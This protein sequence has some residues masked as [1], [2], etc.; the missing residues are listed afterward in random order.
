MALVYSTTK[1]WQ[2]DD[3]LVVG[4]TIEEAIQ[5]YKAYVG[6][7]YEEPESIKAVCSSRGNRTAV[8][9]AVMDKRFNQSKQD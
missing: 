2:I 4:A 6:E 3:V 5:V 8:M 7:N 9:A 1:V